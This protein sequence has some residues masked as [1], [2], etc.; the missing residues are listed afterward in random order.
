MTGSQRVL[1]RLQHGPATAAELYDLGVIVHSRVSDLRRK[2]HTIT[3]ERVH[4]D[5]AAGY[6]YRL[7]PEQLSLE[8]A[9]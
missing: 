2:G 6:L 9:A 5:G 8:T 7:G 4:G 3:C 1:E